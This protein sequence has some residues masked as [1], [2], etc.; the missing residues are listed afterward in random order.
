LRVAPPGQTLGVDLTTLARAETS[1]RV[2]IGAGLLVLPGVLG[3]LWAGAVAGD[4]RAQVLARAVGARDLALGAAAV[5]AQRDDDRAW[6]RRVFA[7]HAFAD[8]VDLLAVLAPGSRVPL[9]SRLVAGTLAAGSAAVAAAY[10][11][12]LA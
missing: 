9:S 4:D 10:A 3:R 2:A 11:R 1:S 5:V 7:A 12:S 6:T 8:A